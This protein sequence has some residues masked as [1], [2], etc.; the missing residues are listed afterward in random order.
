MISV[1]RIIRIFLIVLWF[2]TTAV[3]VTICNAW[4]K[5]WPGIRGAARWTQFWARG[6]ARLIG[7]K[8]TLD[9]DPEAARGHLVISNHTGYLD[10]IAQGAVFPI[11][12]APKAEMRSW[13]LFGLLTAL[14]RPV[15]V[16]RKNPVRAAQVSG[17][18]RETLDHDL[19]MLVYPEG[20]STDGRHGLLPFKSTAFE[21]AIRT[22]SPLLP[23]LIFHK[24]CPAGAFDPAWY[25]DVGFL[26]HI[27]GVLGLKEIHSCVYIMPEV[28]PLPGESR[29]ELAAR[30]HR[31]MTQAYEK[32]LPEN[33]GAVETAFSEPGEL[34][35]N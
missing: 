15:W 29:K 34:L 12:F 19:S 14:S 26:P 18:I 20:T 24:E 30:M 1:R 31:L 7:L 28:T 22:K 8:V 33:S 25:G 27:W 2:L 10:V 6:A 16:D 5:K 3:L 17:E 21:A 35:R 11:R 23:V 13:P 4:R 9:G 32:Y